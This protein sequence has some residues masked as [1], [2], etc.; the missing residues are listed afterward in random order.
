[1]LLPNFSKNPKT[2]YIIG[3]GIT[4]LAAA[5][6]IKQALEQDSIQSIKEKKIFVWDDNPTNRTIAKEHNLTLLNPKSWNKQTQH[7]YKIEQ[8]VISPGIDIFGKGKFPAHYLA[9]VIKELHVPVTI[10]IELLFQEWQGQRDFIFIT[11]TNGKS[12]STKL[13]QHILSK[14]RPA[15]FG[16]NIGKAALS[17]EPLP[18]NGV[19]VLELSSYQLELMQK[20]IPDIAVLLN[21]SYDHL[22]RHGTMQHYF[23]IK[24]KIFGDKK[25]SPKLAIIGLDDKFC[26]TYY[27]QHK[28]DLNLTPISGYHLPKN[29]VGMKNHQL[30]DDRKQLII[31]DYP[32]SKNLL[33][34][35]NAQNLAATY[36]IADY[37]GI[38]INEFLQ[39]LVDFT[40]LPHRQ[41]WVA[42]IN[43]I[44]FINDSKAT[45]M[46][47]AIKSLTSFNNI[48][49]LL[50]GQ[51]KLGDDFSLALKLPTAIKQKIKNCYYFGAGAKK[52]H[53]E[54]SAQKEKNFVQLPTMGMFNTMLMALTTA[55]NNANKGDVILLS[56]AAASFDQYKNF[57]E[58]GNEFKQQV[59]SWKME[60]K[61]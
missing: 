37:Y 32:L 29:G 61:K 6:A 42:E 60:N 13:T 44:E 16:G 8:L 54:L 22:D 11:G 27:E 4:G 10:D 55:K 56:P 34:N 9:N 39:G 17:L 25:K 30:I 45:N 14:H 15:H 49:W 26:Q 20:T 23:Q 53:S 51:V 24:T 52:L 33:G 46:D 43:G 2:T 41:E 7:L 12:T 3:L 38:S 57:E 28:T 18:V 40:P 48:H 19:Y 5:K 59:L 1:M 36:L 21:L 58:R 35:H 31:G 47:S 50:G